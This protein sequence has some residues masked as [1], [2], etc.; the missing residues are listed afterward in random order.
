ML[1][2]L[3]L[4]SVASVVRQENTDLGDDSDLD[5]GCVFAIT[6]AAREYLL[7]ATSVEEASE[8]V[9]ILN[10]LRE[11]GAPT[12]GGVAPPG[13]TPAKR[14]SRSSPGSGKAKW[15]KS[16]RPVLPMPCC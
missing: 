10:D 11:Q 1:A 3:S 16:E 8:W 5:G 6:L 4:P 7:K 14:N 2:A 13:Q 12:K 15:K 9:R